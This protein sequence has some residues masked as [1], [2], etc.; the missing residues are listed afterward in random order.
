MSPEF[1]FR[2]PTRLRTR[3]GGRLWREQGGVAAIEAAIVLPI[4]IFFMLGITELYQYYRAHAIA[5]RAAFSIA[6]GI[7]MQ[8]ELYDGM[9]CD[10]TDHICTY[11]VIMADLMAPLDYVNDGKLQVRL[12][13]ATEQTTGSGNKKTTETVWKSTPEWGKL[14]NGSGAC[15]NFTNT[16]NGPPLPAPNNDDTVLVV[17]VMQNYEPFVMSSKFWQSLGGTREITARTFYRP[18]FDDLKKLL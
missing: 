16:Y 7:A 13:A 6:D 14:C 8:P 2:R 5:E 1:N 15:S 3:H 18:R 12:F 9:P 10:L 11:G 17:E 4:M